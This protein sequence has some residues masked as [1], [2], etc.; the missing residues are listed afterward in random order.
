M[1]FTVHSIPGSP[2]GRAVLAALE[3]KRAPYR[4]AA[5]VP[6]AHRGPEHLARH[7]FGRVPAIEHD[8][9]ALYETSAILRY[10]DRVFPTPPLT[11][12]DPRAAARMDQVMSISDWYL[13]QGVGNVIGFERVVKPRLIGQP[14]DEAACA[15]A[16]PAARIVLGALETLLGAKA[17]L[18][19]E[20][21]S[22]ADLVV[23]PQMDFMAETP[24]WTALRESA[25]SLVAWLAR[26]A[27]RPSSQATTWE[28][29]AGLAQAA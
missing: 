24:E 22:L 2:F 21:L 10:I 26:M 6:P 13:F 25:P 5:V 4:F 3:E 12:A 29:V 20:T 23:Y 11:P 27:E 17:F 9:F 8:G 19:G 1:T 15:A 18:A 14:A 7:P 28:K 16:M